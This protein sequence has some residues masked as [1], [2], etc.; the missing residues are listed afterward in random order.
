MKFAPFINKGQEYFFP[1]VNASD[2][3]SVKNVDNDI[4][5]SL[6]APIMQPLGK[7]KN[8]DYLISQ[9]EVYYLVPG[10]SEFNELINDLQT[11][12]GVRFVGYVP[13]T[14]RVENQ[15]YINGQ[16]AAEQKAAAEKAERENQAAGQQPTKMRAEANHTVDTS[17]VSKDGDFEPGFYFPVVPGVAAAVSGTVAAGAYSGVATMSSMSLA[18]PLVITPALAG[19]LAYGFVYAGAQLQHL[20]KYRRMARPGEMDH[21]NI[22]KA[23]IDSGQQLA[24][25]LLG[26]GAATSIG[27]AINAMES[28]PTWDFPNVSMLGT[29][30]MKLALMV[31]A[32]IGL[33]LGLTA[34]VAYQNYRDG[35]E[36]KPSDYLATFLIGFGIGAACSVGYGNQVASYMMPGAATLLGLALLPVAKAPVETAKAVEAGVSSAF[37]SATI[38]LCYSRQQA[39]IK[40]RTARSAG[41]VG[42]LEPDFSDNSYDN[43]NNLAF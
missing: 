42:D 3:L 10:T 8:Q 4:D 2:D 16:K 21:L 33:G 27:Y 41:L 32:G 17:D 9:N 23:A 26:A 24:G 38:A 7:E 35:K 5:L 39:R 18:A 19:V 12:T 28:M 29:V 11:Q 36:H 30:E 34:V 13:N 40:S 37:R 15:A 14:Y 20:A 25:A 1:E 6:T 43:P 31:F 22:N